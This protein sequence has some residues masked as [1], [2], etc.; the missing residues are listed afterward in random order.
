[1]KFWRGYGGLV[2]LG[3]L[4]AL[5]FVA[6]ITDAALT[7]SELAARLAYGLAVVAVAILVLSLILQRR[8][9]RRVESK[10]AE[11]ES[12]SVADIQTLAKSNST[13]LEDA[14]ALHHA[15]N[16]DKGKPGG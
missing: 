4:C 6:S 9:K 11:S 12:I 3:W 13:L 15:Q 1:M 7:E 5:V 14:I 2:T 16:E 8:L 10:V